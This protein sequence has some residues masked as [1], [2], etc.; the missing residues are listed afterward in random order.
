LTTK[1][2]PVETRRTT[3][4]AQLHPEDQPDGVEADFRGSRW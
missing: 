3:Q 2:L 1:I 4:P